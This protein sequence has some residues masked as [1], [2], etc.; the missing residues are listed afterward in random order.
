MNE[1]ERRVADEIRRR[2][3]RP[4]AEVMDAALY[5]PN[6]GF[7][8]T[9]GSAGRRGDFL[10]SPEVGPLF[11]AVLA[12]A[13]DTWWADMGRPDL[14]TV[15]E[16]GAGP[17]TL[18]RSILAAAPRCAR[19]LRYLAVERSAVLRSRHP[20]GVV[21]LESLPPP[22]HGPAVVLAN[23]LL[24]NF[25]FELWK[26]VTNRSGRSARPVQPA[27]PATVIGALAPGTVAEWREV[28]V[29]LEGAGDDL[30]LVECL[31][32]AEPP[33]W[34]PDAVPGSRAPVQAAAARWLRD[35]LTLAGPGGRVVVVDYTSTT[36][37]MAARPQGEWLRT[38]RGHERG[39]HPLDKLG[40]QD[41][42]VEVAIDQLARVRPP[43]AVGTQADFLRGHGI[44]DLV[45]EGRRTWTERAHIGD[46]RAVR[47]RSRLTEAQALTDPAGLGAFTVLEW[48]LQPTPG[49]DRAAA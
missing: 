37:S 32:A 47:A 19:A 14:F 16:A 44:G 26:R 33:T 1:L 31:V 24:D 23:E 8:S 9:G 39:S 36:T 40:T 46:L 7:Y 13:L 42:T 49:R 28:R 21:S 18:A 38:Y 34:L 11:G 6:L 35:A 29:D 12:R 17:G 25:P 48:V 30:R 10:T 20:P 41:V 2:G 45:E 43:T 4:F 5:D 3:P 27:H 15:V 22:D